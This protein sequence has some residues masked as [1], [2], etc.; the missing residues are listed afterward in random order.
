[1]R[2]LIIADDLGGNKW[3]A[4]GGGR[5]NEVGFSLTTFYTFPLIPVV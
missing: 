2:K 5:E 4:G 1:M 3:A